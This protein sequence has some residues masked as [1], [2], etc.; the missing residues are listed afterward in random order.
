MGA[1]ELSLPVQVVTSKLRKNPI[2]IGKVA[3]LRTLPL[4]HL[5]TTVV[6]LTNC[7]TS[8]R[9]CHRKP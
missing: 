9:L 4:R 2:Q 1:G 6:E 7:R 8:L 5:D 3:N